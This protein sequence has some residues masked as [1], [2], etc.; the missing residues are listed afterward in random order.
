MSNTT[1]SRPNDESASNAAEGN[2]DLLR[3]VKALESQL[4]R[5]G[6]NEGEGGKPDLSAAVIAIAL[7]LGVFCVWGHWVACIFGPLA[8]IVPFLDPRVWRRG[9]RRVDRVQ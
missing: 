8:V 7:G 2:A 9:G 3:R 4:Q 5:R 1:D 6:G